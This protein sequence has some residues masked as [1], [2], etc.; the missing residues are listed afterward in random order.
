MVRCC[1]EVGLHKCLAF[2]VEQKNNFNAG[3]NITYN[4]LKVAVIF[5]TLKSMTKLPLS[6]AVISPGLCSVDI[7]IPEIA[8][9]KKNTEVLQY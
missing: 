5:F 3:T 2:K 7:Y 4:A 8:D 9:K 6:F 1:S